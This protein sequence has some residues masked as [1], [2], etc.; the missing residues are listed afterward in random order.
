MPFT[1]KPLNIPRVEIIAPGLIAA[2]LLA[3]CSTTPPE[4]TPQPTATP[5]PT[6]SATPAP[7]PTPTPVSTPTPTPEPPQVLFRYSFAVRLLRS[8]QYEDAIP[9]F[10]IVIRLLPDF[11]EAYNGRGLA[12]FHEE[13]EDLAF[14]DFDKAIE[15]NPSLAEAYTNRAAVYLKREDFVHAR[16]DMLTALSLF[17]EQGEQESADEVRRLLAPQVR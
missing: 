7:T 12:S 14:E 13:Q 10:D 2:L 11:A 16:R 6:P 1:A 5:L 8:G 17:E 4:P 9:Q 3:G 15:L